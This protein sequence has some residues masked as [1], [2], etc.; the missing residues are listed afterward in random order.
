MTWSERYSTDE[1]PPTLTRTQIM[2]GGQPMLVA[3]GGAAGFV[4]LR[5]LLLAAQG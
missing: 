2:P 5:E 4:I 1:P 3:V